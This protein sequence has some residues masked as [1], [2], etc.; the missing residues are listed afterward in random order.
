[1]AVVSANAAAA[2]DFADTINP[3]FDGDGA[4]GSISLFGNRPSIYYGIQG[5]GAGIRHKLSDN[6]ELSGTRFW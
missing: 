3:Y 1:M 4:S 2:D 5:A 6:T